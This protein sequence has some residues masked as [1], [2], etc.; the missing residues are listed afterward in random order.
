MSLE[1]AYHIFLAHETTEE[2]NNRDKLTKCEYSVYSHFKRFGCNIRRF[3]NDDVHSKVAAESGETNE[4]DYVWN[5]LYEL[6]GHRRSIV[7]RKVDLNQYNVIKIAMNSTI[8]QF[9]EEK[10]IET[11]QTIDPIGRKA[12]NE[13]RKCLNINDS[14]VPKSK[15]VKL[16]NN[17]NDGQYFGSGSTSDFMVGNVFDKFKH[18]FNTIDVI[19]V[20]K[21]YSKKNQNKTNERISFDLWASLDHSQSNGPDYRLIIK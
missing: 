6:L 20:R 19:N 17:S 2:S 4:K 3:K 13:K 18:I 12:T 8:E 5:H 16:T 14:D 10:I 7:S 11:K 9:K 21:P 1:C 15:L